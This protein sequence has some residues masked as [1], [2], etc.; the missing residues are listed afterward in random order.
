MKQRQ[1]QQALS[2]WSPGANSGPSDT[3]SG[4]GGSGAEAS[5][6]DSVRSLRRRV[7]TAYAQHVALV[8]GSCS[9][10]GDA[11]ALRSGGGRPDALLELA[12]ESSATA[13]DAV[14][15]KHLLQQA[16]ILGHMREKRLLGHVAGSTVPAADRRRR[17]FVEFGAG[18]GMLSLGIDAE[19]RGTDLL[20][21]ERDGSST[22]TNADRVLR[23]R[24][25]G[26][27]E[28]LRIDIRDFNLARYTARIAS[29]SQGRPTQAPPPLPPPAAAG[30]DGGGGDNGGGGGIGGDGAASFREPVVGVSKHLCGVATDLTLRC[31]VNYHRQQQQQ[32]QQAIGA[33]SSLTL[34]ESLQQHLLAQQG[35]LSP[36]P[37]QSAPS[38]S[39]IRA[40]RTPA[41][42]S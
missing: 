36:H 31:L 23:T 38:D 13:D 17:T 7:Q 16:S 19:E 11:L 22:R 2:C 14:T 3:S 24:Q 41:W 1:A 10:G 6:K 33:P 30:G 25:V 15:Q 8:D 4:S 21:V 27:F 26:R 5:V 39:K 12:A 28:R 32:Q 20:L 18:K 35:Q 37:G 42:L 29:P 40:I 34:P 9:S